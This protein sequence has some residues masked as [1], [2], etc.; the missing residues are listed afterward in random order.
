MKRLLLLTGETPTDPVLWWRGS[1]DGP[2]DSGVAEEGL[3]GVPGALLGSPQIAVILPGELAAT[4]RLHLPVNRDAALEAAA[5]LAFEDVLAAPADE[6]HF[7]FGS[8]EADGKR[9]VSAVP[10]DW[11][12]GWVSALDEA[13]IEADIVT[14][15]HLA[16][17]AEG[18]RYAVLQEGTRVIMRL[19]EGGMSMTAEFAAALIPSLDG[20]ED[21][22]HISV[23][24]AEEKALVLTDRRALGA[25][26]AASIEREMPPSLLRGTYRRRRDWSGLVRQW[27][28]VGA[29]AAAC[30]VVWLAGMLSDGLRHG[31]AASN[32]E[33]EAIELFT[34]AYPNTPVRDLSRQAASRARAGVTPMFLPLSAEL[35]AAMEDTVSVELTAISYTAGEGLIAD[36]RFPEAASLEALR[37]R[38]EARGVETR[39]GGNIRREEDGRYAGQLL[40]GGIQ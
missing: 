36:L 2:S 8:T 4:R 22:Q 5:R 10:R 20:V 16:I 33:D 9:T 26:Y 21:A 29:L 19:P 13:G 34:Q 24:R 3:T 14:I 6:F 39:E 15:D 35:T 17:C 28:H 40:L 37:Q 31:A 30:M 23:G 25:Y 18:G 38:L 7:A 11:M 1:E 12:A 27:R 32:L